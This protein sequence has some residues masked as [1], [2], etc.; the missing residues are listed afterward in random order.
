MLRLRPYKKC[1]AKYI[2]NW[3]KDE[4]SFRKCYI[5]LQIGL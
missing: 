1:D 5:V 2:V 4:V 3:V